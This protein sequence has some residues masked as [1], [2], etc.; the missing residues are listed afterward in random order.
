MRK[1]YL[2]SISCK[3]TKHAHTNSINNDFS[4]NFFYC[5]RYSGEG[6]PD[7]SNLTLIIGIVIV[8]VVIALFVSGLAYMA[9]KKFKNKT[10]K[11]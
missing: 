5:F 8:V 10:G 6:I 3:R 4:Y 7:A 2:L 1:I 9:Y 11:S